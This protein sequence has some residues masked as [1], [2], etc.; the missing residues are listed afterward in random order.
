MLGRWP[1]GV[2]NANPGARLEC[3]DEI[4][5]QPIGLRDL[6]AHVRIAMSSESGGNLGSWGSPKLIATFC[7]PRSRTRRRRLR[8]YSGTTSCAM[9]RPLE[10]TIEDS[11]TS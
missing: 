10:P 6:M 3:R 2:D 4:V 9:M 7:N 11:R 8:K 1:V 5:E